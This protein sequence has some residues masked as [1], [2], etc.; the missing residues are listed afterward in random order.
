VGF[1]AVDDDGVDA[2]EEGGRLW[3]DHG[4]LR[5]SIIRAGTKVRGEGKR[6]GKGEQSLSS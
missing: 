1:D 5:E 4:E 3:E 6:G 2:V